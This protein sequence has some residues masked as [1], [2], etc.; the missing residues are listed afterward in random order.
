[1]SFNII[2]CLTGMKPSTFPYDFLSLSFF[3]Y[4]SFFLFID[5]DFKCR[6]LH[7]LSELSFD[8]VHSLHIT[9]FFQFLRFMMWWCNASVVVAAL[10]SRRGSLWWNVL[11][12]MTGGWS[13]GFLVRNALETCTTY[14][15]VVNALST[16]RLVAPCYFTVSG[17]CCGE[18][19]VITRD[20]L[21][22]GDEKYTTHAFSLSFFLVMFVLLR[23]Q[24]ECSTRSTATPETEGKWV[25][26]TDE[27]WYH[28]PQFSLLMNLF[29]D[30]VSCSL[31]HRSL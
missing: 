26:C 20:R 24:F 1:M 28:C 7:N 17:P 25:H 16:R 10:V 12:V 2:G 4:L 22:E 23:D 31:D 30:L 6:R 5:F 29:S 19:C 11:S 15:D 9:L 3:F 14:E 21:R 27:Y 13:V 18:G 8:K